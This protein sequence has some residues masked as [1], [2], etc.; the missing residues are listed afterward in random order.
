MPDTIEVRNPRTGENDYRICVATDEII[1]PMTASLRESQAGWK[2]AGLD[3]RIGVLQDGQADGGSTR[4]KVSGS[5]A[6][7]VAPS[8]DC[9]ARLARTQACSWFS[10][11]RT[12]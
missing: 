6:S 3:A 4:L 10:T 12:P 7:A 9:S 11:V 8:G 2:D 5:A 1:A